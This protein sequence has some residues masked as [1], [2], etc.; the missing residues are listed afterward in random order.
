[1]KQQAGVKTITAQNLIAYLWIVHLGEN[2][3]DGSKGEPGV[4]KPG[5]QGLPGP[6]GPPGISVQGMPG[7]KGPPGPPGQSG[8]PGRSGPPVNIFQFL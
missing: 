2:G 8:Y 1:M 6:S 3:R 5:P 4:S 7:E